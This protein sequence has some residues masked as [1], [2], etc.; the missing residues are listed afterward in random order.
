MT[1]FPSPL[2][3]SSPHGMLRLQ[4]GTAQ[5]AFPVSG[6]VIEVST[7]DGGTILYRGVT[8]ASGIADGLSLPA[9]PRAASQNPATA[10]ESPRLYT[11]TITHPAFQPQTHPVSLFDGITT[12][13]PVVLVPVLPR[14]RGQR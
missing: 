1:T 14:E 10:D 5:G 6:A 2:P 7:D 3:P 8:D 13:L 4:V 11:V 12:I 9:N